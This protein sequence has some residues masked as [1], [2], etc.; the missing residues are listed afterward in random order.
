MRSSDKT[1]EIQK[2]AYKQT[3][4]QQKKQIKQVRINET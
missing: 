2:T 4:K 3:K 1:K